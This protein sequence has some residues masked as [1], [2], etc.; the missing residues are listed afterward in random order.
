MVALLDLASVDA[1]RTKDKYERKGYELSVSTSEAPWESGQG[2]PETCAEVPEGG[3][4]ADPDHE[5]NMRYI[6]DQR[7]SFPLAAEKGSDG[8]AA[9][10]NY[11]RC[12]K[13]F[14][15]FEGSCKE[16]PH[17]LYRVVSTRA[18]HTTQVLMYDF[19]GG[20][21]RSCYRTLQTCTDH[22]GPP[23]T[24]EEMNQCDQNIA[25]G[26][27][28]VNAW[29]ERNEKAKVICKCSCLNGFDPEKKCLAGYCLP[30]FYGEECDSRGRRGNWGLSTAVTPRSGGVKSG[31][32][33]FRIHTSF[34]LL[35]SASFLLVNHK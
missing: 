29:P 12:D 18:T 19:E 16:R 23:F 22:E 17:C 5:K 1:S 33:M 30:Y 11:L 27:Y 26:P 13:G 8:S 35:S 4:L 21:N 28:A 3:V 2:I 15:H 25:C 24:D 6:A 31:A 20:G 14:A 32:E 9:D 10:L 34:L 7:G